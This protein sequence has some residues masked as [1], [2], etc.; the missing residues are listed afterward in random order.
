MALARAG[1]GPIA[2]RMRRMQVVEL[3]D[4]RGF[5]RA[6]RDGGTDWL[7]FM[8]DVTR[9]FDA[10]APKVRHA[11]DAAGTDCIVDLCSGG[12][13]PWRTLSRSLLERGPARI[14]LT[15]L[16]P[17]ARAFEDLAD[18][19]PGLTFCSEPVDATNVPEHL[20]GVR[21]MFNCFHHFPPAAARAILADAVRKRRAIAIFEGV[22]R[23]LLPILAMPLQ[24][25]L[26]FLLTPWVRPRKASRFALTY[27]VPAIPALVFFDGVMSMLRIY[28]PDEL[29]ELIRGVPGHEDFEWDV[30][31]TEVRGSPLGITH[32]VGVPKV[33]ADTQGS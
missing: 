17:N 8:A 5:P 13:G 28:Q 12:G 21:T 22:D 26:V 25:A 29:T 4:L 16:Y 31:T 7:R 9:A 20:S 30:G 6:I 14:Q 2:A 15:D 19:V 33:G 18:G 10:I 32:L 1:D 24:V 3:E 23:R 11:M 27:L